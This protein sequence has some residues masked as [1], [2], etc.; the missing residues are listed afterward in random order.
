V[1]GAA[2]TATALPATAGQRTVIE[3]L[4]TQIS[5]SAFQSLST[6]GLHQI[7][8]AHK[9]GQRVQIGDYSP[10]Q[11]RAVVDKAL[12]NGDSVSRNAVATSGAKTGLPHFP[13]STPNPR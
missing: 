8:I 7:D 11:S 9:R 10:S 5:K 13:R 12:S 6:S 2:L 1:I 3:Q 4:P